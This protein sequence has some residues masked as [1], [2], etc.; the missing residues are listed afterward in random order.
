ATVQPEATAPLQQLAWLHAQVAYGATPI[1]VQQLHSTLRLVWKIL[2]QLPQP[3][4]SDTQ[5]AV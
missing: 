1:P 3:L 5:I 2:D 4:P